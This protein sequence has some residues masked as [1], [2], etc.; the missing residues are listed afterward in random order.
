MGKD[1]PLHQD[2]LDAA[3][4]GSSVAAKDSGLLV[5]TKLSI[6]QQCAKKTDSVPEWC[7][8]AEGGDPSLGSLQHVNLLLC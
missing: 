6:S 5:D 4:L 7:Q 1:S 8:Q 3:C 2:V